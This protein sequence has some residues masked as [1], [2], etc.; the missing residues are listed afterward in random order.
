MTTIVVSL[1]IILSAVYLLAIITDAF[2]IESLQ[3][4]AT[5]WKLPSDVAGASLMA[6]GSSAPELGIALIAVFRQGGAHSDIGMAT[7]VGSAVFNILVITGVS[8]IVRPTSISWK[9]AIRDSLMYISSILTL[10]VVFADGT[11]TMLEASVFLALYAA[12]LIILVVWSRM[13]PHEQ[14]E[15]HLTEEI[16]KDEQVETSVMFG[17]NQRLERLFGLLMGDPSRSYIRTFVVSILLIAGLSWLLVDYAV[18][19]ANA[20]GIPPVIVALTI[21]AA[22]TSAPD[23]IASV[24]VAKQGRGDMAISNAVGSN[25]FDIL[26][27]LGLPWLL[28]MSFRQ[29]G[30][31]SGAPLVAVSTKDLWTSTI[32]L[33]GSAVLLLAFLL[34]GKRLS[35]KEGWTL[36]LCY[37]GYVAW[38]YLHG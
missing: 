37:V 4:I 15:L 12:Y 32:V 24:I 10:L 17:I 35:R 9:S 22:G 18:I 27:G 7:I 36:I 1:L 31:I 19:F 5:R 34:S 25:I 16:F 14:D 23:L 30:W 2:F 33:L 3:Q 38:T 8:A 6:M 20:V 13:F 28:V 21:L 26:V 11:I 29:F